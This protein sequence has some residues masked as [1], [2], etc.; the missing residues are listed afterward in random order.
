MIKAQRKASEET[1]RWNHWRRARR[2]R[3]RELRRTAGLDGV[4]GYLRQRAELRERRAQVRA[5]AAPSNNTRLAAQRRGALRLA[6]RQMGR[7]NAR[8]EFRV[9]DAQYDAIRTLLTEFDA[10]LVATISLRGEVYDRATLTALAGYKFLQRLASRALR[11]CADRTAANPLLKK[12]VWWV[13][14]AGTSKTCPHCGAWKADLGG[15]RVYECGGPGYPR[16]CGLRMSRDLVG[17]VGN[18]QAPMTAMLALP[19]DPPAPVWRRGRIIVPQH[20]GAAF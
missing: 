12:V 5:V 10:V 7:N 20:I 3:N 18:R 4:T 19:P 8:L 1:R 2:S 14:E 11:W 16:G 9:K 13:R 6:T 15:G 17:A